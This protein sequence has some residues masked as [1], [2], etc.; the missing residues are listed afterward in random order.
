VVEERI[1]QA[2][3]EGQFDGLPL[4]QKC[5]AIDEPYDELWW[6]RRFL[7]REG[8][9]VLPVSLEI[10]R[11]VQR[12]LARIFTLAAEDE[13]RVEVAKLNERIR[14]ANYRAVSGPPSTTCLLEADEVVAQWRLQRNDMRSSS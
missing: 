1:R 12:E 4:G 11:D 8:L 14:A 2:Q 5:A 7:R 6:V 10:R 9:A 13:V 3:A